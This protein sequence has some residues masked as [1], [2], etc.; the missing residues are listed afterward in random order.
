M[1]LRDEQTEESEVARDLL[2]YLIENPDAA[3]TLEGIVEWW[4]LERKIHIG[5]VKVKQALEQMTAKGLI[6][7]RMGSDSRVRYLINNDRREEIIAAFD[8]QT[9]HRLLTQ[10]LPEKNS[11]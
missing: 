4:L 5:I 11:H 7:A 2:S 6:L 3:D 8:Q 9:D 1:T 10:K